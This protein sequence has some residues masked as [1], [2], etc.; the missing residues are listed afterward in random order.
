MENVP[1]PCANGREGGQNI[2][3]EPGQDGDPG[4]KIGVLD[5]VRKA[6]LAVCYGLLKKVSQCGGRV[7]RR[8]ALKC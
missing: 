7:R 5:L 2:A 3:G 1:R 8:G 4:F 6:G